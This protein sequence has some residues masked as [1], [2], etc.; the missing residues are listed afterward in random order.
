MSKVENWFR[1]VICKPN[2]QNW[3]LKELKP[4]WCYATVIVT[5]TI[6][7]AAF[8]GCMLPY[9]QLIDPIMMLSWK[10]TL[11]RKSLRIGSL[12]VF[13]NLAS[14]NLFNCLHSPINPED[15]SNKFR[16]IATTTRVVSFPTVWKFHD[17]SI[18]QILR[19]INFGN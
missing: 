10:Y 9:E 15:W 16:N 13:L 4:L 14:K 11:T 12:K 3:S 17:F 1:K 8:L 18:N 19:E 5:K 7:A 2:M 6:N